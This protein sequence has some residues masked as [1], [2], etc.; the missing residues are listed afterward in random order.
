MAE[1]MR[2]VVIDTFDG[3]KVAHLGEMPKPKPGAGE[4]L[5]R[6]ES[7]VINPSDLYYMGGGY[8]KGIPLPTVP[9]LEGAG[10]VV[11]CGEGAEA[12]AGKRV[13]VSGG[14]MWGEYKLAKAA[15]CV[16]LLD[17]VDF[18][19]GATLWVN[20]MTAMMFRDLIKTG[21]H[22]AAAQNAAN[23]ALG[24][25]LIRLCRLENIP[26]INVVRSAK[27][28]E[29]IRA[30]GAEHVL[31]SS[32]P[33]FKTDYKA[34]CDQLGA[35]IAFDAVAGEMTGLMLTGLC[36]GGVVHVYGG[37]SGQPSLGLTA[38]DLIFS[39]KR[40]EGKMMPGWLSKKSAEEKAALY[41]EV[42]S[43]MSDVFQSEFIGHFGLAQVQD[44]LTAYAANMSAGKLLIHPTR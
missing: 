20:P 18:D 21:S 15:D 27:S 38:A 37:L 8:G 5:V 7:S 34:I 36:A 9:G 3:P 28:A 26:L 4:V 23:S 35:T 41:L 12:L 44:A 2:A 25:M 24:K 10:T 22:R 13:H 14:G 39:G 43:H 30:E 11:E 6:V 29:T 17:S 16:P 32:D 19:Q 1:Q 40:V 31:D 33:N 42:Q